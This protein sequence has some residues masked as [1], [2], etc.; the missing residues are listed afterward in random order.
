ME[1]NVGREEEE[2]KK[3]DDDDENKN[4]RSIAY[5]SYSYRLWLGAR[6]HGSMGYAS[7]MLLWRKCVAWVGVSRVPGAVGAVGR[8]VGAVGCCGCC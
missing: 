5:D 1:F 2:E 4:E 7:C 6:E 3:E 8:A